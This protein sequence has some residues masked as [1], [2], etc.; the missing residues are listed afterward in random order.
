M[1]RNDPVF[2]A[3]CAGFFDGEGTIV[4][5]R[6]IDRRSPI[7]K[8]RYTLGV[9]IYQ[10][11]REPLDEIAVEFKGSISKLKTRVF[12][13]HMSSRQAREFLS[14]IRPYCRV[15]GPEIDIALEFAGT[16]IGRAKTRVPADVTNTRAGLRNQLLTFRRE[17]YSKAG[18]V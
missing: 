15:K 3:W 4:I 8:E 12:S 17:K 11:E 13:L 2:L 5:P 7:I 14:A 10:T 18:A 6:M 1:K 16:F 9:M